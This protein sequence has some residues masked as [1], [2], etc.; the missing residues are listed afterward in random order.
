MSICTF[1][2]LQVYHKNRLLEL[3]LLG[4]KVSACVILL[5]VTKFPFRRIAPIYT[6]I[7]KHECFPTTSPAECVV[8][9]SSFYLLIG[10]KWH[11]SSVSF[12]ISVI[13]TELE[14][15]LSNAC[16]SCS[17]EL[18][19]HI[20]FLFFSIGFLVLWPSVLRLFIY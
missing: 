6:P 18:H 19:V 10:E 2:L 8:T 15:I 1:V 20:P 12:C 13:M 5:A 11:I 16:G 17:S 3:C 7:S 4:L 9:L 14:Y